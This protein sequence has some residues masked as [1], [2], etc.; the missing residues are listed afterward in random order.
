M[1]ILG[2][3]SICIIFIIIILKSDFKDEY[4]LWEYG[5]QMCIPI[6]IAGLIWLLST[7]TMKM[8][9]E[10]W[11]NT[12]VKIQHQE[13]YE[14]WNPCATTRECCCK[15][16]KNGNR[17]CDTECVGGCES[18]GP[19]WYAFNEYGDRI[20]IKKSEYE[21][22]KNKWKLPPQKVGT[23]GDACGRGDLF[24][25]TWDNNMNNYQII[26]TKH[27][28]VNKVRHEVTFF[29]PTYEDKELTDI[30]DYPP[31]NELEQ[32]HVIGRWPYNNEQELAEHKLDVLN[33]VFGPKARNEHG[34]IK[35]FIFVYI[36]KPREYAVKQKDKLLGGN[37]NEYS[38]VLGYNT[39]TKKI[40]WYDIIT[41][42]DN[43]A[44]VNRMK[45]FLFENPSAPLNIVAD[46]MVNIL[47]TTWIRREF[48]P[49]NSIITLRPPNWV[50]ILAYIINAI[51]STGM[52]YIFHTNER[53]S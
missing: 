44:S 52:I 11:G 20:D 30:H 4:E 48:T 23:S 6:I 33:G 8:D 36:D 1:Y 31:V 13:E 17:E 34:Q 7:N 49:L 45:E 35:A 41:Y 43:G 40:E 28:Y 32:D 38:L 19:Y 12:C 46:E 39:K 47:T 37:K 10:Y 16:D 18:H 51:L 26:V 15:T 50:I 42:C 14:E 25:I 5:L 22:I 27:T 29:Y 9:T 3:L 21:R 53:H 24:E 2:Q